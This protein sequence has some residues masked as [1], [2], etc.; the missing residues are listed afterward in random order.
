[1]DVFQLRIGRAIGSD[2]QFDGIRGLRDMYAVP[3]S[4]KDSTKY[5]HKCA[6]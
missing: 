1:M 2:L 5:S 6:S 3:S 4:E